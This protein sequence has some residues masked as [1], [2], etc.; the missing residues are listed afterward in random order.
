MMN[1]HAYVVNYIMNYFCL[2]CLR[3]ELTMMKSEV[4]LV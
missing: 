3:I 2:E 1:Y 4:T